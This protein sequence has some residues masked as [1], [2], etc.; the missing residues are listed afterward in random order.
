MAI[1]YAKRCSASLIIRE[2]Q[3]KSSMRKK[4]KKFNEISLPTSQHGH[5]KNSTINAGGGVE[6]REPSY[7]GWECKSVHPLW[8][9]VRRG[10]QTLSNKVPRGPAIPYLGMDPEETKFSRHCTPTIMA[11]LD[12][13]AKIQKNLSVEGQV[14]G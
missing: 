10:F 14:N 6:R 1:K 7:P 4:K 12:T 9:T 3:I 11:A 8:R 2:P 13:I 5:L